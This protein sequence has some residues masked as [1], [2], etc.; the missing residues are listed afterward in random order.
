M[1]IYYQKLKTVN[2]FAEK[3]IPLNNRLFHS[4]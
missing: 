4:I 2:T 1:Q 3:K